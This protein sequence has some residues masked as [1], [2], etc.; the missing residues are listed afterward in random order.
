MFSWNVG[1][2]SV[3]GRGAQ[4]RR[5]LTRPLEGVIFDEINGAVGVLEERLEEEVVVEERRVEEIVVEDRRVEEEEDQEE[6]LSST[7]G[8]IVTMEEEEEV[9]EQV[10]VEEPPAPS[11]IIIKMSNR[12]CGILFGGREVVGLATEV[13]WKYGVRIK[14]LDRERVPGCTRRVEIRKRM[15][16]GDV[17]GAV[18][19]LFE[20][21][22]NLAGV[23]LNYPAISW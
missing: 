10:R 11:E 18:I 2:G 15:R 12:G 21:I 22:T 9:V 3:R 23:N 14:G 6:M 7:S 20:D 13:E 17:V 1:N 16:T 4:A 19:Q 5:A 8:R